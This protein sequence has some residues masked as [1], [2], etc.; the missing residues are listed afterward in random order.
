MNITLRIICSVCLC[1]FL[2]Q[3]DYEF[4]LQGQRLYEAHCE[5]C[6]ME[7]GSGLELLI[8]DIS[9]SKYF[10]GNP[11]NLYCLIRKGLPTERAD[12][13]EMPAFENLNNVEICNLINYLNNRWS[14]NFEAIIIN[15]LDTYSCD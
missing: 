4:Y 2:I 14:P 1:L 13:L 12:G 6:H 8:P 15:E 10:R 11:Q 3:C 7:D 9:E 5:N